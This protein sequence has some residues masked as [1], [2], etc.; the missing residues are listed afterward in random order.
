M[1]DPEFLC[2]YSKNVQKGDE[3]QVILNNIS[4]RRQPKS[5]KKAKPKP[6]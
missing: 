5:D 2:D 6:L 3:S 1:A 4:F